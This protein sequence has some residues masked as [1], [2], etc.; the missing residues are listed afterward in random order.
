META[1]NDVLVIDTSQLE[2]D[3][4]LVDEILIPFVSGLYVKDVNLDAG[5]IKVDWQAEW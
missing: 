5:V 2:T 1:A 4:K 3:V